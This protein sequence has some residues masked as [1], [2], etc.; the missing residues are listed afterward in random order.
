[1]ERMEMPP[2]AQIVALFITTG[3]IGIDLCMIS[4]WW[5]AGVIGTIGLLIWHDCTRV[6]CPRCG[7]RMRSRRVL[8][9]GCGLDRGL[10][11]DCHDCRVVW[12]PDV[13]YSSPG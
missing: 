8:L 7:K 3:V 1:M 4:L 10:Y 12:D 13:T 11:Y 2:Q 5:I 6:R 9:P